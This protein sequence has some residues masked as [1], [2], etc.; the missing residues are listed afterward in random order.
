MDLSQKFSDD[1]VNLQI[2]KDIWGLVVSRLVARIG[3]D[4][5][6]DQG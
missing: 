5:N 4:F 6:I 3:P 1:K 2:V